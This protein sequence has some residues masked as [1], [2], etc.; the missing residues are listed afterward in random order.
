[1]K[2]TLN[3]SLNNTRNL[4]LI[5]DI[6]KILFIVFVAF[7]F[8]AQMDPYYNK[9]DSY[10]YANTA[11][12]LADNGKYGFSN[13]LLQETGLWEFVPYSYSKTVQNVAVPMQSSIGMHGIT[14]LAYLLGGYYGL[15]YLTPIFSIL[16]I[17]AVDRICIN[18]FGRFAAF[19]AVVLTG[20][21]SVIFFM[22]TQ[23]MS[24][25]IFTFFFII[26]IYF[27]VKFFRNKDEKTILLSSVFLVASSFIRP[28]GII[29]FPIE[30]VLVTGFLFLPIIL[31]NHINIESKTTSNSFYISYKK[32]R[33]KLFRIIFFMSI[34]W[35]F[36]FLFNF[37]YNYI[38]F[39]D[40]ILGGCKRFPVRHQL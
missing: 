23:L 39:D 34:P 16:L 1:M 19:I 29:S 37:A 21:S 40:F 7:S 4:F 13:E 24:E 18:L 9:T 36:F 25:S 28:N 8:L 38:Y 2:K 10:V 12:N 20:T 27:L 30:L 17:I 6:L 3:I 22:G 26:G 15:F 14:T 35:L 11:I 31:K 5:L 33:K 32:N